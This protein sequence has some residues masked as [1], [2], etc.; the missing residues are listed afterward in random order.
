VSDLLT[1]R[2][3]Q[4]D[5]Q[6]YL[7]VK[8]PCPVHDSHQWHLFGTAITS[9]HEF[10][11][12]HAVADRIDG[13][14]RVLDPVDVGPLEGG[15]VG[16]PGVIAESG[17]L[18]MFL[19][20]DY[21]ALGGRIEHL[22]SSDGGQSFAHA[23]TALR[24]LPGTAEAGIYDAHPAMLWGRRFVVYSAFS[25]VGEPDI[26]LA[27]SESDGW[28]GP[29]HRL[30]P[31]LRHEQVSCHNQLGAGDYEWGL[32][33]AQLVELPDGR[34]LLNAVCFLPGEPTGCRQRVFFSI[35]DSPVGPFDVLGPV[36]TP[37][38]GYGAGENGHATAVIHDD[39]VQ[40]FL[41]QRPLTGD[42]WHY[43]LATADVSKIVGR[44]IGEVAA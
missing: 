21:N 12:L 33:G 31:I 9:P 30:G 13:P 5:Q 25:V 37:P 26:H 35:G 29:W 8:D 40:V 42:D 18:H 2:P 34:I 7:A 17:V 39:K 15:C 43:A 3:L 23:G 22:V 27:V 36:L 4:F 41:Q 38:G 28:D 6:R 44:E 16:A 11:L 14:W 10:E 20:T 32:E 19:Q 1:R 24:S